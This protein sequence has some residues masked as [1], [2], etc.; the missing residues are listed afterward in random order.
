MTELLIR[1]V[2]NAAALWVAVQVVPQLSFD[3]GSDWW[4]LAA[5]AIIFA[6]VNSY[7]KPILKALSFP[8][9]MMTL[10]LIAFIINAAMLLVTAFLSDQLD[11][12]FRIGGFPPTLDADAII[13]AIIGAVVISIVS[14]IA[15]VALSPR[16]LL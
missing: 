2:I 6:L 15:S 8:I 7:L 10:G 14:T 9:S 16:K 5:V 1:I 13:G 11:L 4:K 12:G 3:F